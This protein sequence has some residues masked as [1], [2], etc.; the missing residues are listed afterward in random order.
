MMAG[1]PRLLSSDD[2]KFLADVPH[3]FRQAYP[4]HNSHK[5]IANDFNVSVET[6]K[7]WLYKGAFPIARKQQFVRIAMGRL[8]VLIAERIIAGLMLRDIFGL[9]PPGAGR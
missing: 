3:F 2:K 9:L 4:G 5:E 8:E 1:K 7:G 6:A